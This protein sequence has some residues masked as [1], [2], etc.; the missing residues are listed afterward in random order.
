MDDYA[1]LSRRIESLIRLGTIAQV[2]HDAERVRVQSGDLTSHW[3]PWLAPR[4]GQTRDWNP[5]T[6]GEQ[7][8]L[9]CP[10]GDPATAIVLLGLY[11]DQRPAPSHS[12]DEHLRVYPDGARILYNHAAGALSVSG[13]QTATVQAAVLVTVSCPETVITGNVTILGRLTVLGDV[14]ARAKATVSGL[15]SY[16]AGMAGSG[17][18]G[19]ASTTISGNINHSGGALSSNGVTLHSHT[20]PDPH[21]GNTE[22]P[23]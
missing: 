16:L 11:S 10:S 18:A 13:I 14:I 8:I 5:P 23:R 6:E 7:V 22:P 20:H 15:F 1:D 3:L 12:P 2:D 21:G 19:G 9:L 17:G 4:A